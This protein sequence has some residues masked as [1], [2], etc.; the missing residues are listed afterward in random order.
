[1]S[2]ATVSFEAATKFKEEHSKDG[3]PL[4][5]DNGHIFYPDGAVQTPMVLYNPP[6][7]PERLSKLKRRYV[8]LRLKDEI[9][10]FQQFK[11]D[12]A[13]RERFARQGTAPGPPLDAADQLK[14]GAKRIQNLKEQLEN[15]DAEIAKLPSEVMKRQSREDEQRRQENVRDQFAEINSVTY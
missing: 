14:A 5:N 9:N 13:E 7:D 10:A 11:A 4:R 15:L 3:P 2:F 1:M 8:A 12:C 6:T